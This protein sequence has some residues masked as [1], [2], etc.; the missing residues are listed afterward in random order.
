MAAALI[1]AAAPQSGKAQTTF[2]TVVAAD[3]TGDYTSVQ[4][5]VNACPTDGTRHF[6]FIKNGTY[7]GQVKVPKGV[8]LS[9]LGENRDQVVI[10]HAVSHASGK[11]KDETSTLY[12]E[13]YD[14]YGEGF[15]TQNTVG[16]SGGQAECMTNDGDRLTLRDV[17]MKANQ[18]AVRFDNASR[19][20][21]CDSYI[22]GTVDYI[23]DSGIAFLDRCTI[24][25]LRPG[26]IIA[27]GDSYV[28]VAR[29]KSK[30]LCGQNKIWQLGINIRDSKL[31]YDES[32]VT[33]GSSYLGR[34]WGKTTSAGMFIR[35]KMDKHINAA[36][37]TNMSEGNKKYIGEYKSTDLDGKAIDVSQRISWEFTEDATHNSQ[38]VD[39]KV[40]NTIYDMDF[41]YT[42]AGESGARAGGSFSPLPMVTPVAAPSAI[43]ASAG[44]F[45]WT[46]CEG[47]AGYLIYKNG[48]YAANT[49]ATT[50]TDASYSAS[51]T[52]A[53][54][55]VS[56]TGCMGELT[57]MMTNGIESV[58]T[59]PLDVTVSADGIH[60]GEPT[61][62][63]LYSMDGTQLSAA[64]GLS[65]QWNT[66]K[67]GCYILR[68][69][70][71]DGKIV[72]K[73]IIRK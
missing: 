8:T 49:T 14:M 69:T 26:Y 57:S 39:E 4:E 18:D 37:F 56:A 2:M 71:S 36:G 19:T 58:R 15:T 66:A 47:V 70:T 25:Q 30:E 34:P 53:L 6:V 54:R 10:T 46:A 31:V 52:Y 11:D 27:P 35:C 60:F 5:A 55:T 67:K 41:V 68:A 62:A 45:S 48:R 40:V 12:V 23:Y 21:I 9:L 3:G 33:S 64:D 7:E 59:T 1:M 17:A 20:Y 29:A 28:A 61:R 16:A 43:T 50:Y 65:L 32:N 22:E 38:Y 73:K 63:A 72:S 13:A 51:A 24:K 42:L 44:T